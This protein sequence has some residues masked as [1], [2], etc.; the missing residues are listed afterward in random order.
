MKAVTL[1]VSLALAGA[2]GAADAKATA[3]DTAFKARSPSAIIGGDAR[4][5]IGGDLR[6][7]KSPSAIIGG[8]ARAII[9]GDVMSRFAPKTI[10]VGP[11]EMVSVAKR[12][13]TVLGQTYQAGTSGVAA[14]ADMV[15]AGRSV[16]VS[17]AGSISSTGQVR[18]ESVSLMPADYVSGVTQVMIVGRVTAVDASI[19]KA[20]IGGVSVDY[21]TALA[22]Q[23]VSINAGSLLAVVGTQA[24]PRLAI[25]AEKIQLIS[26]G[27]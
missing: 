15:A 10:V 6:K 23:Q 17:V 24:G 3:A 9:G 27:M 26:R 13:L 22:T 2:S 4:A 25:Q 7:A 20:T 8:D 14:L 18:A 1:A 12:Q 21:T 16:V 11:L 19:G 5:I